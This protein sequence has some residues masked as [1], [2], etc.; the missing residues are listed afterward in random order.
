MSA[1]PMENPF[2]PEPG[3]L[4]PG[5][6]RRAV[7]VVAFVLAALSVMTVALTSTVR[8]TVLSPGYYRSVLD[9]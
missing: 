2:P 9:E 3:P 6:S 7:R 4:A 8:A 1:A 5:R